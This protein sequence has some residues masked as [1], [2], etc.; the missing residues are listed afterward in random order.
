MRKS[1]HNQQTI[2]GTS[3]D[4]LRPASE[5]DIQRVSAAAGSLWYALREHAPTELASFW[6]GLNARFDHHTQ[7]AE[8]TKYVRTAGTVPYIT[9]GI[10]F[11]NGKRAII[12]RYMDAAS[13]PD[14]SPG[15]WIS[16]TTVHS[17]SGDDSYMTHRALRGDTD[18]ERD[19]V[20][21]DVPPADARLIPPMT[22]AACADYAREFMALESSLP[23]QYRA[24]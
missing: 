5:D 22:Q 17:L 12:Y 7:T 10:R 18:F 9:V 13:M 16:E 11:S 14:G 3:P 15:T 24:A 8:I 19:A 2:P 6:P 1:K 4:I 21:S 20:I 23:A